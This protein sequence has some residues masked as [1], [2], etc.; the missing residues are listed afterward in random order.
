MK[1]IT[2]I[3]ITQ[4]DCDR[5]QIR[6][7]AHQKELFPMEGPGYPETYEI[8]VVWEDKSYRCAYRIGSRDGKLRSGV[9]R[10][11]DG[12]AEAVG[13]GVRKTLI[14]NRTGSNEYHLTSTKL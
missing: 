9:L 2:I 3:N 8:T 14:L 10:L 13:N 4:K 1:E 12:L 11:K 6:I 7:L 5:K